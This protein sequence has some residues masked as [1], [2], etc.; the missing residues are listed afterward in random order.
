MNKKILIAST[1]VTNPPPIINRYN[2]EVKSEV[3]ISSL[4]I[5]SSF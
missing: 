3:T 4:T 2:K 5:F 1:I